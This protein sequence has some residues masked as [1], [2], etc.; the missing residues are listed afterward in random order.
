M[1]FSAKYTTVLCAKVVDFASVLIAVIAFNSSYFLFVTQEAAGLFLL[2]VIRLWSCTTG[3]IH[4]YSDRA[5]KQV[6]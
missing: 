1:L 3:F 4:R 5:Q 2:L 6:C